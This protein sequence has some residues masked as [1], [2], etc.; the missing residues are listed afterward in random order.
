MNGYEEWHV[1]CPSCLEIVRGKVETF[2]NLLDAGLSKAEALDNMGIT[3]LCT[4]KEFITPYFIYHN[5]ENVNVIDGYEDSY[6][7][8]GPSTQ[9]KVEYYTVPSTSCSSASA[10]SQSANRPIVARKGPAISLKMNTLSKKPIVE[11][12]IDK[13][14]K[15]EKVQLNPPEKKEFLY[16]TIP[17]IPVIN[18]DE[19]R[20]KQYISV[21]SGKTTEVISG[22]TYI[23]R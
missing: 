12:K 22:A 16:P 9:S 4:R 19:S 23:A 14:E 5:M 20:P 7:A 13:E 1:R 17:G 11:T 8:S 3:M 10:I 18:Y 6:T 15:E 2:I 21:G